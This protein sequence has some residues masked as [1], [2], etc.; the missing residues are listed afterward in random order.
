MAISV[1][2]ATKV[3]S[4]P[5]ADLTLLQSSPTEIRE[6]NLNSFRLWLRD[7][8]DSEAGISMLP[9]H[10]HNTEVTVGGLTLAR[11]IEMINGYTVTFEN[12]AYAV[13]LTG[14]NSNVG[15]VVNVNNV[16]VR[17]NNS[18]GLINV[19]AME[20]PA[21]MKGVVLDVTHGVSGAIYPTGTQGQP[22]NNIADALVIAQVRGVGTFIIHG[23]LS[24]DTG[25]NLSGYT[26]KGENAITTLLTINPG[27]VVTNCQFEDMIISGST[28]DGFAYM[29]HCLVSNVAGL[30]GYLEGCMLSS[31][32][33]LTGTQNTYFVDCK[34]GC[35]GLGTADLPVLSMA[36]SGRHVAFRNYAGPIKITNSTDPTNTICLDIASGA[37]I[38]LDS[39][40]TAGTVFVRGIA[41]IVNNSTMTV[42]TAA[43]LDQ[44]SIGNAVGSHVV[45]GTYTADQM[46]RIMASV[47]SG[48]ASGAGTGLESF[49]DMADLKDRVRITV[50]N[51]GNRSGVV[52]D[53]T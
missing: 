42:S 5:K 24:L 3:I 16:S 12:G 38:T 25:D 41:N 28:L 29:K 37:T 33:S 8:E 1:D 52:I 27:A 47:L 35:V 50:D 9:T 21:Y 10:N 45:E 30:E 19:R 36:G 14:A 46:F 51:Q 43:Q 6:L 31:A 2:P 4:I 22:S 7:W 32:L 11:V 49:R 17:A 39:S 13:N 26:L 15:D 48:K 53:A 23:S 40:C 20:F 34:S 44:A 18:A